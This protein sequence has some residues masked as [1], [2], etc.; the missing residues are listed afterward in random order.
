[1]YVSVTVKPDF[2][3]EKSIEKQIFTL[4]NHISSG[5]LYYSA[6]KKVNDF[7]CKSYSGLI[8]SRC[9]ITCRK[10]E[11]WNMYFYFRQVTNH[12]YVWLHCIIMPYVKIGD[13]MCYDCD[14]HRHSHPQF[15]IISIG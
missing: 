2:F 5:S 10:N 7:H 3:I 13:T 6:R 1:M 4:L 8:V 14:N 12:S 9:A 11:R 15:A